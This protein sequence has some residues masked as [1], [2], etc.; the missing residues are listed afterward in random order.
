MFPTG[1]RL[2]SIWNFNT[3]HLQPCWRTEPTRT[4]TFD[5]QWKSK[6]IHAYSQMLWCD[7]SIFDGKKTLRVTGKGLELRERAR[8]SNPP[9]ASF[10]TMREICCLQTKMVGGRGLFPFRVQPIHTTERWFKEMLRWKAP[11]YSIR[12]LGSH[13]LHPTHPHGRC[14]PKQRITS[15]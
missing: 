9:K 14:N 4:L 13:L 2:I 1:H 15:L 8:T 7:T 6:P 10:H 12:I 11:S 5:R 3:S